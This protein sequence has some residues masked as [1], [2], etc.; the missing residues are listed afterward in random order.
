MIIEEERLKYFKKIKVKKKLNRLN[1]L[2]KLWSKRQQNFEKHKNVFNI[3]SFESFNP[4]KQTID[5]NIQ[6]ELEDLFGCEKKYYGFSWT[7]KLSNSSMGKTFS[8]RKEN[9]IGN[10]YVEFEI[11]DVKKYKTKAGADYLQIKGQD[12]DGIEE[13]I[14]VWSEDVER[15]HQELKKGNLI[16]MKVTPPSK[17]FNTFSIESNRSKNYVKKNM[18]W[19]SKEEDPRVIILKGID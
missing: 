6:S 19:T 11:V 15:W 7:S 8:L 16:R 18:I 3:P 1:E 5:K 13:R 4:E 12:F 14:N 17:G 10:G 2:K 9:K